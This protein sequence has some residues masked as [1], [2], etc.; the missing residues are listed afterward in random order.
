MTCTLPRLGLPVAA[1]LG[2]LLL[3]LLAESAAGQTRRGI[4]PGLHVGFQT[5]P[6]LF[7]H[8]P[9]IDRTGGRLAGLSLAGDLSYQV[10]PAWGLGLS[11]GRTRFRDATEIDA[12]QQEV[13]LWLRT[14]LPGRFVTPHV[15]WG[16][17]YTARSGDAAAG[18]F[19]QVGAD[20]HLDP[21]RRIALTTGL[22][23]KTGRVGE[24]DRVDT[25]VHGPA[26]LKLG[27]RLRLARRYP[28]PQLGAVLVPDTV[29]AGE[30]VWLEAHI[31]GQPD[32]KRYGYTWTL[33]DT[34]TV[35]GNPIDHVFREPGRYRITVTASN[36]SGTDTQARPLLVLPAATPP[37]AVT[38]RPTAGERPIPP[39][40]V[41]IY[42]R[43]TLE[44]GEVE[45]FHVR[46]QSGLRWPV[47]H[48]WDMG[49][50]TISPGNNISHRF[51]APG[52][53]IV[54][55]RSRNIAGAD[56]DTIH[57]RVVP[58]PPVETETEPTPPRPRPTPRR[59]PEPDREP[60]PAERPEQPPE[61]M[62][63]SGEGVIWSRGGYTWIVATSFNRFGAERLAQQYRRAGFRVG[64]WADTAG[65]GTTAYRVVL[66]QFATEA[67]ALAVR[68]TVQ[69]QTPNRISLLQI[70]RTPEE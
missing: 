69:R 7:T 29:Y 5:G 36:A 16:A 11:Y 26:A 2:A 64:V 1:L 41:A 63:R 42:G 19:M 6:A 34:I 51:D 61:T 52:T 30:R 32:T 62:L 35:R 12:A 55:V 40:I 10:S 21:Q 33:G 37:P 43:R 65:P 46:V 14:A 38:D 31:G 57:V 25:R 54:T 18:A 13:A 50:G 53:Y 58:P 3:S 59:D 28:P 44:V 20:W 68:A 70:P 48:E 22:R 56:E 24:T 8:A 15:E 67:Q 60:D 27:L 23:L 9:E 49:D 47:Q 17:H 4:M 39:E 66:G 45:H